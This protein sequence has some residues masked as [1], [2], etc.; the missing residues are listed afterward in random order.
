MTWRSSLWYGLGA[1]VDAAESAYT[2]DSGHPTA[3]LPPAYWQ[4]PMGSNI[5]PYIR[6][7]PNGWY[8]TINNRHTAITCGVVVGPDTSF[9]TAKSGLKQTLV[10]KRLRER[11]LLHLQIAMTVRDQAS[12]DVNFARAMKEVATAIQ[13]LVQSVNMTQ[14]QMQYEKSMAQSEALKDQM[15]SFIDTASDTVQQRDAQSEAVVKD[16]EIDKLIEEEVAKSEADKFDA[17][18]DKGLKDIER[19]LG[20]GEPEKP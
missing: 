1:I 18:I 2:A 7:T 19:Q 10:A 11:Q 16:E 15:E 9:G 20:G 5:G 3:F 17:E 12:A 8:A 4:R 14:I 6:I 13:E